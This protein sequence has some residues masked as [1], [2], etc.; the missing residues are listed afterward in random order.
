MGIHPKKWINHHME[1]KGQYEMVA[2][3]NCCVGSGG[4][5]TGTRLAP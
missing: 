2:K 3:E 4:V 5:K 1:R